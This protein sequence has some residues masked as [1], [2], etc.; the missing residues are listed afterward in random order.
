MFLSILSYYFFIK[1]IFFFALVRAQVKSDLMKDHWLFLGLLYTA[2]V[3]FLSFVF[4]MSWQTPSW[5]GWQMR[6]AG[7]I[8]V[9]PWVA[10]LMETCVISLIYF[11]LM[12][13]FDEGAM[14]WILLVLGIPLVLF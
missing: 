11:K 4:I 9:S 6:V 13:R 2:A 3:A 8:G 12:A 14:F 5:P 1:V 10:W 7:R